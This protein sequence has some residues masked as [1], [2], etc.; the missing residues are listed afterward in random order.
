ME[1]VCVDDCAICL[2][3]LTGQIIYTVCRHEFHAQCLK[4]SVHQNPSCPC[5]R[6]IFRIEWLSQ[7]ELIDLNQLG[8]L[9]QQTPLPLQHEGSSDIYWEQVEGHFDE[10][11][12]IG[13]MLPSQQRWY[14]M[15]ILGIVNYRPMPWSR[16]WISDR[17]SEMRIR[18]RIPWEVTLTALDVQVC[19]L[20]G[21]LGVTPEWV[22][23][24]TSS[25]A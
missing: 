12:L 16:M 11:P 8:L 6:T 22:K 18:F 7:K 3:P 1:P 15:E 10:P 20:N 23:P 9:I 25:Q 4:Q 17:I 13:P 24:L 14:D 21:I 19:E 2:E 5:C